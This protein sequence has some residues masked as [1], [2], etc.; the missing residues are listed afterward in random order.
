MGQPVGQPQGE[1][2]GEQA[3]RCLEVWGG[4]GVFNASA[5]TP[6]AGL[7]AWVHSR[8]HE[9]SAEGGDIHYLSSCG[10]GRITRLLVADVAGHGAGVANLSAK[11]RSL[12]RRY[13]HHIRQTTFV[14]RMNRAFAEETEGFRF[15]TAIVGTFYEPT[16][17]LAITNAGHPR[18][19]LYSAA[20]GRWRVMD[21]AFQT[22]R[23][24]G[25]TGTPTG[26]PTGTTPD[27]PRDLPLGIDDTSAYGQYEV[28]LDPGD[29]VVIYTDSLV[30]A[31]LPSD[32]AGHAGGDAGSHAAQTTGQSTTR[33]EWL[34][35]RGLL[36]LAR[37]LDVSRPELIASLLPEL[38]ARASERG[39]AADDDV[40]VLV[41]LRRS[42][43]TNLPVKMKLRALAVAVVSLLVCWLPASVR[44]RLGEWGGPVPLPEI[45]VANILGPFSASANVDHGANTRGV[46][47][48]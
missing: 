40:T 34:G 21:E 32:A 29:M 47:D 1:P 6:G 11:L 22:G 38:V 12:M 41:L 33:S 14:E 37:T 7:T 26:T 35:E 5:T 2:G 18:P 28:R 36:V 25:A 9:G 48:R 24:T 13:I 23:A 45:S 8:P 15:A 30:E 20:S 39:A 44:R 27:G 46:D 17:H 42:S 10:T 16:S 4:S 31:R 19:L 3:L 43:S